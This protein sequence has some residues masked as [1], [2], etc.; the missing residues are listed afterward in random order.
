M[1]FKVITLF[2]DFIFRLKEYS[3]IGRALRDK[4]I[5]LETINLRDFGLGNYKQVDDRPYGGGIGML[6][7]VD[8]LFRALKK[9]APKKSK[10]RI[11]ILLSADGEKFEQSTAK[12]LKTYDEVVLICGHYEG[13][14]KRIEK[15]IDRKLSIGD[16][17][18]TG[19]ELPAMAIIDSISR[20]LPGVL[21]KDESSTEET[22]TEVNGKKIFEYPQF[23][24]PFEFKGDKVPDVLLS[25]DHKKITAWQEKNTSFT[26]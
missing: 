21:G 15:Y 23:T 6:L 3:I 12:E 22:F 14:D 9:A 18:L 17:I 10:K 26:S 25:G 24:R 11:I 19:G 1:K 20:L 7:R 8:V 2:P 4:K 13:F 5:S 16:F